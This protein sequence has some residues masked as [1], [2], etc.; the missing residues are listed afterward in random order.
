[1]NAR[2][3]CQLGDLFVACLLLGD[4]FIPFRVNTAIKT[5]IA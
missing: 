3:R 4:L 2:S 1:M 5:Y